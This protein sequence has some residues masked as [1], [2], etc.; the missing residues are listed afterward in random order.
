LDRI[1]QHLYDPEIIQR[2]HD[3]EDKMINQ[4][5]LQSG[6]YPRPAS[7][8][9]MYS[10]AGD[11]TYPPILP[12]NP[13]SWAAN[14]ASFYSP[15]ATG[16][17]QQEDYAT[18]QHTPLLVKP[19]HPFDE[20]LLQPAYGHP[21]VP[22]TPPPSSQPTT[23]KQKA[24]LATSTTEFIRFLMSH[25]IIGIDE[26]QADG[27]CLFEAF[28]DQVLT[29]NNGWD[30]IGV[31]R[32]SRQTA[33]AHHASII[34]AAIADEIEWNYHDYVQDIFSIISDSAQDNRLQEYLQHPHGGIPSFV[35]EYVRMI[36]TPKRVGDAVCIAAFATIYQKPVH[37]YY[38]RFDG[39][40]VEEIVRPL[41]RPG[42]VS[43][44]L[45]VPVV[46]IAWKPSERRIDDLNH[47]ISAYL[48]RS[49]Q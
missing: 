26:G 13:A 36:R 48:T 7:S 24:K 46:R 23:I 3:L 10:H 33:L 42:P 11:T 44:A 29:S 17:S 37:V 8:A 41:P 39:G 14:D 45:A 2:L 49:I 5:S 31:D 4:P 22:S 30:I 34:R 38:Q 25:G 1:A 16:I 27:D 18:N 19:S 15:L 9:G 43:N 20:L 21:L 40:L 6:I 32:R 47:Y 35:S 12:P 28:S